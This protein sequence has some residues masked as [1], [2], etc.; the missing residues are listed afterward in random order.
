MNEKYEKKTEQNK[1]DWN[2]VSS[3]LNGGINKKHST[4]LEW[5]RAVPYP[6]QP[7]KKQFWEKIKVGPTTVLL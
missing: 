7:I 4:G 6:T 1:N 3:R 5:K 2:I